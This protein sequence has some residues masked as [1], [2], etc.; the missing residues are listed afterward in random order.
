MCIRDRDQQVGPL[1]QLQ[2]AVDLNLVHRLAI[3]TEA[4][5]M[6]ARLI[7]QAIGEAEG[8]LR[9]A[10]AGT[11]GLRADVEGDVQHGAA[12]EQEGWRLLPQSCRYSQSLS[13]LSPPQ[14]ERI[15]NERCAWCALAVTD[16]GATP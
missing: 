13:R 8:I 9:H 2:A 16:T 1:R 3:E 11:D 4:L 7:R 5:Q 15:H 10:Q 12:P 6:K 14:N